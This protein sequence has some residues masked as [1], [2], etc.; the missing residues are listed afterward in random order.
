MI[1]DNE[2]L[3]RKVTELKEQTDGRFQF[4]FKTLDQLLAVDVKEKKKI[5]N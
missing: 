3:K 1:S 5:T 4:V 2:D